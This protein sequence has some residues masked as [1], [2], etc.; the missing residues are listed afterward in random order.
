MRE[1]AQ[2]FDGVFCLSLPASQDRRR[3]IAN[4]F[5]AVGIERYEFFDATGKDDLAVAALYESGKVAGYPPCFRCGAL[6]CGRDDC[7]NVLIPAQVATFISFVNLWRHILEAEVETALIV[8]DD[9]LF[10]DYAPQLSKLI[11]EH[12]LLEQVGL[13]RK[14]PLLLR[15]GWAVGPDHRAT[16]R[17]DFKANHIKM[18]DPCHALNRAMAAKLLESFERVDTTVDI[19]IH[20]HVGSKVANFTL[21]PP[22]AAELSWS[23]GAVDSLIHPKP[24][25]AAY[26]QKHHPER[27]KEIEAAIV[28]IREHENHVLY[29]DLL[30]IGHPRC[31]SGYMSKL[32]DYFGLEVGHERMGGRGISSWMFAVEDEQNPFALDSQSRSRRNTHFGSVIH[33]VRDPRTAI[34]SII[35]ENRHAEKSYAFRRKHILSAFGVDLDAAQSE[36]ERALLSYVYWNKIIERQPV[37]LRVRVEEAEAATRVFLEE[38]NWL[39]PEAEAGSPPPKDINAQKLYKGKLPERPDL[40]AE[41]WYSISDTAKSEANEMCRRYGYQDLYGHG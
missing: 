19:F 1:F 6:S 34:P 13:R 16:G 35:R 29:R 24:I 39:G 37:D 36:V 10:A 26:L 23:L 30:L 11:V 5:R 17:V 31:G 28:A 3:H 18:S 15:L 41:D 32:L 8:E 25:R 20:Q 4:H 2:Q 12:K 22:L 38:R 27:S 7:N 9:V 14:E 40:R 21:F 33:F